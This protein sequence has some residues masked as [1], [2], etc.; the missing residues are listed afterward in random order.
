[1]VGGVAVGIALGSTSGSTGNI[2]GCGDGV[3]VASGDKTSPPLVVRTPP[4]RV[5][6]STR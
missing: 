5:T 1:L 4:E 3:G 2:M 6:S